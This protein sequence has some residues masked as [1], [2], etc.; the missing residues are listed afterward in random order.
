MLDGASGEFVIVKVGGTADIASGRLAADIR[1]LV[2]DGIRVVIAHGGGDELTKWRKSR[3]RPTV[4]HDGLRVTD[5]QTRDDAV[6][7]FRGIVAPAIVGVLQRAGVSAVGLSG[8]DGGLVRVRRASPALGWVG[9]VRSVNTRILEDLTAAGHVPVVSPLGVDG[10][11]Q[12]YNVNGDDIAAAIACATQ[13]RALIFLT[14]V[15]GVRNKS[16]KVVGDL[17]PITARAM[18]RSGVVSGGMVPKV[19]A[20]LGLLSEVRF[21]CIVNGTRPHALRRAMSSDGYGTRM[22][23]RVPL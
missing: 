10:N 2:N 15:D 18:V 7:V 20:A 3:R 14:D 9:R 16:G 17:D 21:V 19:R 11:G 13:A 1:E 23:D 4:W 6:L 8:P 22:S 5:D 12:I